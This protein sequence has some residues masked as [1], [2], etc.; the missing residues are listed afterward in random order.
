ML[1]ITVSK[2]VTKTIFVQKLFEL[3]CC[4]STSQVNM[5]WKYF[6]FQA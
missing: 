3:Y 6:L 1:L 4:K 5:R 2:C